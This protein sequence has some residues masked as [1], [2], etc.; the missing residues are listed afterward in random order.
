MTTLYGIANCDQVKKAKSWLEKNKIE[1]EFFDFKK[2]DLDQTIVTNWLKHTE[3]DK[4][5]NTRSASW[6]QLTE[7]EKASLTDVKKS[8]LKRAIDLLIKTPTLIKRPVLVNQSKNNF[9]IE[10]GFN[11]SNYKKLLSTTK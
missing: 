9:K 10:F 1:F 7:S 5:V 11:E 2:Q 3:F 4:I 8:S 6:R